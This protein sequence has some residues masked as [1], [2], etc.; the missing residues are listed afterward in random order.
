MFNNLPQPAQVEFK[1]NVTKYEDKTKTD[2]SKILGFDATSGHNWYIT[3][4]I[5]I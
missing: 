5:V 3:G 4:L 1:A 2:T